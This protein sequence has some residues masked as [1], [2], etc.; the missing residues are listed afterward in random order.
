MKSEAVPGLA[1]DIRRRWQDTKGL[2]G[3]TLACCRC[4]QLLALLGISPKPAD[5]LQGMNW[6]FH[7]PTLLI[8]VD[9]P[10]HPLLRPRTC[11]DEPS[12]KT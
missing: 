2:T 3:S 6:G 10:R 12:I 8:L 1:Y 7:W 9:E 5:S 11:K 4:R